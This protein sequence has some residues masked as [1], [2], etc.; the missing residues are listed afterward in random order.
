M[1]GTHESVK[2]AEN[3]MIVQFVELT[4][5]NTAKNLGYVAMFTTNTSDLTQ[6]YVDPINTLSKWVCLFTGA[7]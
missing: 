2:M 7:I 5:M 6:V 1:L 4:N 3:V